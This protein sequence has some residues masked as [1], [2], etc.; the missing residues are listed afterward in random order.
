VASLRIAEAKRLLRSTDLGIGQIARRTGFKDQSYFT[1]VF[2]S[3]LGLTPTEFK[4]S[5]TKHP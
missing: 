4:N 3:R 2:K 5:E 1:K